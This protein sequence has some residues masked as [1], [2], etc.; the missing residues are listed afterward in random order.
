MFEAIRNLMCRE[1][2]VQYKSIRPEACKITCWRRAK[3]GTA[4]DSER[5]NADSDVV[6]VEKKRG[7]RDISYLRFSLVRFNARA[8][9]CLVI[10]KSCPLL[11]S[12]RF[13]WRLPGRWRGKVVEYKLF[14]AP[15]RC[16]PAVLNVV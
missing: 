9:L 1:P 2:A 7:L 16:H 11:S 4:H 14:V 15:E 10:A 5:R 3:P 6:A 8:R 13:G 12:D